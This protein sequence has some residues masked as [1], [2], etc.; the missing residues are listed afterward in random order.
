MM[1]SIDS[2]L[3]SLPTPTPNIVV[4]GDMNFPRSVIQWQMS[5]EGNLFPTVARHREE[6]TPHGKQD[7]LQAQRLLEFAAKHCLQQAVHGPTHGAEC[8]DLI[9]SNNMDLISS[10]ERTNCGQFSGSLA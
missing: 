8:L 5:E 9:W 4:M 2:A 7:R 1:Q 3:S 6:E 10:C